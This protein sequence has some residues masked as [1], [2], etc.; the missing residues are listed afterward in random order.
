VLARV[1]DAA[2]EER[3][4]A[5]P[6]GALDAGDEVGEG[7][8]D[9]RGL[10]HDLEPRLRAVVDRAPGEAVRQRALRL[11]EDADPVAAA[12][13]EQAAHPGAPVDRDEHQ[14]RM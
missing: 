6:V 13:V 11:A 4:V 2:E 8:L 1:L 14:G 5:A 10:A 7:A 9:Q 3:V 12:L